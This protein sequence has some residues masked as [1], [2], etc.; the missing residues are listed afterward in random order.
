MPS[1]YV[2]GNQM[3]V[4]NN[5]AANRANMDAND[6]IPWLS[7]G[8]YGQ[9]DPPNTRDMIL[10][11][12]ANGARGITYYAYRDFDPLHF[13]Y[14]AEAIDIVAP[15]EDII[16]DGE[17]IEHLIPLDMN[18]KF[19][20]VRLGSEAVILVS[21]YQGTGAGSQVS[22]KMLDGV[23]GE[24]W[25][26]HAKKKLYDVEENMPISVWVGDIKAHMYYIGTKYVD[27]IAGE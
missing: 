27:A 14:H 17:P 13:K 3:A 10:E 4:A 2:A 15:V 5:I 20:G 6:I 19:C 24:L 25:D 16:A 8:T 7:P 12:F 23:K 9:Y 22:L 1:L 11:A 21:N 26:L 18:V